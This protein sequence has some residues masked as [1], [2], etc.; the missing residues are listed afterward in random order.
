MTLRGLPDLALVIADL[1]G[2]GAQRVLVTLAKAWATQ[3][4]KVTLITLAGSDLDFFQVPTNVTRIALNMVGQSHSRLSALIANIWRILA[5]R[6]ALQNSQATI[7]ISFV[8]ATNI[9]TI[10]ATRGLA[11]TV[12]VSER[13]DPH[14]QFLGQPWQWLRNHGYRMA[15]WVTTNSQ[16]VLR[17][18]NY[19]VPTEKL[20]LTPNPVVQPPIQESVKRDEPFFLAVGRLYHQ[21]AYDVL[22]AGLAKSCARNVGWRL[23]ILG[24]GPERRELEEL[25]REIEVD[26]LVDWQGQIDNPFPWYAGASAFVLPS[27]YEGMPNALLEAMAAGLPAII[28]DAS[29][30]PLELIQ[31]GKTGF[32]IPVD[33]SDALA[34]KMNMIMEDRPLA[35][36]MALA[37]QQQVLKATRLENVLQAWAPITGMP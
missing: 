34:K 23:V 1:G 21:K 27:R 28:S 13:N 29:P 36:R 37:G 22:L 33:D 3:N 17:V 32:I 12:V 4:R 2:G 5:L 8:A 30:G 18:L 31:D 9:L 20:L 19:Y 25:S 26:D 11:K 15:D 35:N 16:G 14:R 7:V 24:D 10:L 6:R